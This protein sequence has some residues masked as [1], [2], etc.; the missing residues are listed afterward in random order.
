LQYEPG[1]QWFALDLA[2]IYARQEKFDDAR[3]IAEKISATAVEPE[4]RSG[5]QGILSQ[6]NSMAEQTAHIK[7]LKERSERGEN[8]MVVEQSEGMTQEEAFNQAINEALRKPQTGEQRVLGYLTQIDCDAKGQA[9]V[10]RADN[11]TLKL[12]LGGG[13]NLMLMAFTPDATGGQIGCGA[14]KPENFVVATY[15]TAND[16]KAKAA[17]EIVALEFVPS[18][19][20]LKQ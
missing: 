20:K 4:L 17:G 13:Q 16:A 2:Q 10:V 7:A 11:Q 3:K 5:A 8:A 19:F 14:R 1:N 18:N 12:R 6:I 9:F 15:R